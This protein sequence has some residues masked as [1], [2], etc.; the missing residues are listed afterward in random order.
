MSQGLGA[1]Q[2]S[3]SSQNKILKLSTRLRGAMPSVQHTLL[4]VDLTLHI[5]KHP[6]RTEMSSSL[7]CLLL[8]PFP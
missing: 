7:S 3:P 5:L 8:S 2:N 4:R 1:A 6:T